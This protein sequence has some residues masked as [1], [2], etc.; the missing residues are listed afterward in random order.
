MKFGIFADSHIDYIHDGV[1]RVEKFY[2][3][4]R[5]NGVDF[6]IQLGDFCSPYENKLEI[7]KAA[8][9]LVKSQP[10]PTYH[11]L[12]NHDMDNN[13]KAEVLS[14]I[15]QGSAEAFL[16]RRRWQ[17]LR[18]PGAQAGQRVLP[19]SHWWQ[20]RPCSCRCCPPGRHEYHRH[21]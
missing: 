19:A 13:S 18:R 20:E 14:F 7:K 2:D 4:A 9:A 11:V 12:G 21:P 1:S 8:L 6:C 17:P 16:P 15:G 10:M 3:A 5:E